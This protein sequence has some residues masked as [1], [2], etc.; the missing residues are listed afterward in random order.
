[1]SAIQDTYEYSGDQFKITCHLIPDDVPKVVF[2]GSMRMK[3]AEEAPVIELLQ[4]V[5]DRAVGEDYVVVDLHN[6][7]FI[8]SQG[9]SVLYKF[10]INLRNKNVNVNVFAVKQSAWQQATLNNILKLSPDSTI[11]WAEEGN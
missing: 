6:L 2:Q 7:G 11:T 3:G 9:I 5:V 1:M 8:N 10:T 4:H